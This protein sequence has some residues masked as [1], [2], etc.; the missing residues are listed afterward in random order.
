VK[1]GG[2]KLT[3]IL[4][5]KKANKPQKRHLQADEERE[6][7]DRSWEAELWSNVPQYCFETHKYTGHCISD[8]VLSCPTAG[9]LSERP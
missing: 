7:Q 1:A 6:N 3:S 9:T 8:S 4:K 5:T 2:S